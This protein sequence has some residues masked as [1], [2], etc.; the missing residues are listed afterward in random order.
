MHVCVVD[1]DRDEKVSCPSQPQLHDRATN[2]A[3]ADDRRTRAGHGRIDGEATPLPP[4]TWLPKLAVLSR[5]LGDFHHFRTR[6]SALILNMATPDLLLNEPS[7]AGS[8]SCIAITGVARIDWL[9]STP[10]THRA[11]LMPFATSRSTSRMNLPAPHTCVRRAWRTL[12]VCSLPPV[13]RSMS[14][15][16]DS[17]NSIERIRSAFDD[18]SYWQS[19]L[20]DVRGR[21]ADIGCP[22]HRLGRHD[23]GDHD[24]EVRRRPASGATATAATGLTADRSARTVACP[25]GRNRPRRDRRRRSAD[26]DLR[27]RIS[28]PVPVRPGTQLTGTARVDVSVPLI[29]GKIAGFIAAQLANGIVDIVQITDRGCPRTP[30]RRARI[31]RCG[32]AQT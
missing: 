21:L 1:S 32:H 4:S 14:L 22:D 6:P 10:R 13:P 2:P 24:H 30:E 5:N 26:S 29:G 15:T 8:I 7:H 11:R 18:E 19:R 23:L 31:S 25:G 3:L 17:P 12:A 20:D 16:A 27:R 28:D 9:D